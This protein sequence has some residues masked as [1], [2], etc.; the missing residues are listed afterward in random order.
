ML[1]A[2]TVAEDYYGATPDYEVYKQCY[3]C[4]DELDPESDHALNRKGYICED[5]T[6]LW[7]LDDVLDFFGY[8]SFYELADALGKAG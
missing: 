6:S 2:K 7:D 8:H 4:G 1:M 5:C 3:V